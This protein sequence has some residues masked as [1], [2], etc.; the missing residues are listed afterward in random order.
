MKIYLKKKGN[1]LFID[2]TN[3]MFLDDKNS[4]HFSTWKLVMKFWNLKSD[5]SSPPHPPALKKYKDVHNLIVQSKSVKL[6]KKKKLEKM[7][8]NMKLMISFKWAYHQKYI[9]NW[10]RKFIPKKKWIHFV[11]LHFI[12]KERWNHSKN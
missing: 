8:I 10:A 11:R 2:K 4:K 9:Q 6:L 5:I 1:Y 7:Y 12:K 3:H